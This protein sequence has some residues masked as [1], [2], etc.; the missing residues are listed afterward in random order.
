M[1]DA[2]LLMGKLAG[3]GKAALLGAAKE[4]LKALLLDALRIERTV[5]KTATAFSTQ[6]PGARD[7]LAAWVKTE[8]FRAAMDSFSEAGLLPEQ[9]VNPDDFLA[10]TGLS[11][12]TAPQEAVGRLLSAF[13]KNLR[14]D[15]L[16]SP[17]LV[18]VDNRVAELQREFHD[19]LGAI[20][21]QA[22]RG[23]RQANPQFAPD[24]LLNQIAQ[25]QGWGA[26]VG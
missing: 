7:A 18:L 19:L 12:G 14:E 21:V 17:G 2:G 6:L 13:F 16:G 9:I 24:S 8:A 11:F 22:S 3:A 10:S 26:R 25:T 15:L 23:D 4:H 1:F 5:Q 20:A